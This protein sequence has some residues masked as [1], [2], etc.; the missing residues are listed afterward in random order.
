MSRVWLVVGVVALLATAVRADDWPAF[1][2]PTGQGHSSE[3]GLPLE[4]SESSNVLWKTPVVGRGWSSP[5]VA[6]GR[7]WLTTATDDGEG[8]LRL[9]GY[10]VETG[11]E[12]VNVEVFRV[13]ETA[14]ANPKNSQASPTPIVDVGGG[15]VYVHFGADGTG[16]VTTGGDVVWTATFPYVT[17][18]GNGGSPVLHDGQLFLSVD[19]YDTAYVVALDAATGQERWRTPR[20]QPISQAYS[21]PL[22]IRVGDRDQLFS[23][24]AF[25][26]TAYDPAS[27][28]ALWEVSYGDGFSNVPAPVYGHGMVYIATGFQVPSLIAVRAN[29][30]GDVTRTHTAWTLRRGAPLTP[31]PLLVGDELYVVSDLGVATCVDAATGAI[32][33]QH[34]LGGNFSASPIWADGRIYFQSEEGETTVITPGTEFQLLA[35]NE[36]DGVTLASP[37]VADGSLFIRS[38]D[39]LYRI[40]GP[41]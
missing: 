40:T 9:L 3:H 6:D 19:G 38:H 26:A 1:R 41:S 11:Q 16:A 8:S 28:E 32:Y 37:A 30:Q 39:H 35:T 31:S 4:W 13:V 25:R 5:V 12:V 34:R 36:L 33:W 14:S 17:Q 21:T 22:V 2:G 23:I 10:D 24:G 18:H 7:V 27:G 29:G 20:R 15:R